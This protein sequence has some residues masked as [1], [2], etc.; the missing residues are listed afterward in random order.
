MGFSIRAIKLFLKRFSNARK[1]E[2]FD[3]LADEN[4]DNIHN[5][6]KDGWYTSKI[7]TLLEAPGIAQKMCSSN[8][9]VKP[10]KEKRIHL[11]WE[12][13]NFVIEAVLNS[14][15]LQSIIRGYLGPGARLDDIYVKNIMDGLESASEGWHDDN[16][17]YRL[18]LFMVFDVEGDPS[19]TIVIPTSRPNLYQ[20]KPWR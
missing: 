12:V 15:L 7:D 9:R 6:M 13:P 11:S 10:T 19:G 3:R 4:L 5:K 16:V 2:K 1:I 8:M 17:G 18:K 14:E 20:I